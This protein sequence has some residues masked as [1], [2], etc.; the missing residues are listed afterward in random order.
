MADPL[1]LA[2]GIAGL[3]SLTIQVL[4]IVNR[5]KGNVGTVCS[6][7]EALVQ[8]LIGLQ[9]ILEK[10]RT[11]WK[12]RKLGPEFEV[13]AL[14]GLETACEKQLTTLLDRLNKASGWLQRY[15][16]FM[17]GLEHILIMTRY[18][19]PIISLRGTAFRLYWPFEVEKTREVVDNLY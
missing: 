18:G 1:S 9:G 7:V 16:S 6:D 19:K 15:V 10:L 17:L 3:L 5:F 2:T 11:A 13:S 14:R 8:E 4:H 12:E